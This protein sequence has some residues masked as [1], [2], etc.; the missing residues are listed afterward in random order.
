[1]LL[2]TGAKGALDGG[3]I[4]IYS[5]TPPATADAAVSG[6][7]LVTIQA[8]GGG[9]HF[10]TSTS[11]PGVLSKAPGETWS[12]TVGTGGLAS[13]FRH[14]A[15]SDTGASSTTQPRIQGTVATAGGDLNFG[16]TTL[17]A[18]NV[19]TIDSYSIALPTL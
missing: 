15:A 6:T 1:M 11:A 4:N 9:I 12:G 3:V 7:L 8:S 18:T 5:G 14:V 13:Y 16:N 10:D 2:S 17:V 19:Q